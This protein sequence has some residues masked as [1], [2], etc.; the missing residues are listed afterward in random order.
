MTFVTNT[1]IF[2]Q[3]IFETHAN[4]S[5]IQQNGLS[6]EAFIPVDFGL[7]MLYFNQLGSDIQIAIKG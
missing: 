3:Y 2:Y 7:S 6:V 1:P 4:I 5:W